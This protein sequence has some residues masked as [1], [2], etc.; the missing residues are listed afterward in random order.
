[1]ANLT[2]KQIVEKGIVTNVKNADCIQQVG[3]DLELIEIQRIIGGGLIPKQGKTRL[4]AYQPVELQRRID[5]EGKV[6][7]GW[8]LEPGAYD[9]VLKQG[10]RI[11]VN[12][13][14]QIVQRSSVL[15]NGGLLASSMFDPGFETKNIGTVMHIN[16]PI[17]IEYEARV[18][19]AYCTE[20]N[21]VENLYNG[22]WQ[23]DQQR[24]K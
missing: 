22:Q 24:D 5:V 2:G 10:C 7:H 1:M 21:E 11:P 23:G 19:Q 6:F 9:I 16:A 3:V 14:L 18:A 13:R 15:R 17:T 20:V 12:Q 4:P 8:V